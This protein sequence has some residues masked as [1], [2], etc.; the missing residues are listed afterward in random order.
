MED[1]FIPESA[2]N[3][4]EVLSAEAIE[5]RGELMED[6]DVPY[7]GDPDDVM[8]LDA[9]GMPVEPVA[10]F[11]KVD[12]SEALQGIRQCIDLLKAK[13]DVTP[14]SDKGTVDAVITPPAVPLFTP[15]RQSIEGQETTEDNVDPTDKFPSIPMGNTRGTVVKSV[16]HKDR[17]S[18]D[19][20][21][22]VVDRFPSVK[23]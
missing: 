1:T 7:D 20:E 18:S 16:V 19:E 11:V 14:S 17:A 23:L 22:I 4:G 10:K 15:V 9:A 2:G 8:E 3:P 5:N 13:P 21:E 12:D 6:A